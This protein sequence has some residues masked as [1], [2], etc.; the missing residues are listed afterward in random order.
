[1]NKA[2]QDNSFDHWL[3]EKI[4]D[5]KFSDKRLIDRFKKLLGQLW[6]NL[7]QSIPLACQDWTNTKAA[8]RFL[9]KNKITIEKILQE[10]FM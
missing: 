6:K 1:M 4:R 3:N 2:I 8:Y 9:L 7:V 5:Q 10:H